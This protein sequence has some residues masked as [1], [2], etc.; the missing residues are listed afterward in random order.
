M[1]GPEKSYT[2]EELTEAVAT[3]A[4]MRQVARALGLRRPTHNLPMHIERLGLDTSHFTSG[5]L[6]LEQLNKRR[7]ATDGRVI[8][9]CLLRNGYE[10]KCYEC[11]ITEWNGKPAP[12]QVDHIDG[13]PWNQSIDNLRLLC[14][15][16]HAQTPTYGA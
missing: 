15:N 4:S 6:T 5:I 9:R 11:G 1:P 14:A 2:D 16:C 13:D 3:C 7:C 10:D 8:K 12:I